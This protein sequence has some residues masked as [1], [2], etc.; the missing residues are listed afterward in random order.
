MKTI[1]FIFLL[2][3]SISQASQVIIY[4]CSSSSVLTVSKNITTEYPREDFKF[5]RDGNVISFDEDLKGLFYVD[6][7]PIKSSLSYD[8]F[9]SGYGDFSF[10]NYEDGDFYFSEYNL[11]RRTINIVLAECKILKRKLNNFN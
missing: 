7:V 6:Q 2:I 8:K 11:N 4:S 9:Y 1:F 10:F 3:P 5:Y